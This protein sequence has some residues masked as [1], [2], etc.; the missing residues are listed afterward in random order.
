MRLQVAKGA[1]AS[2]SGASMIPMMLAL[3]VGAILSG[4]GLST[5]PR[6]DYKVYPILGMLLSAIA[7]GLYTLMTPDTPSYVLVG[8]LILGGLGGGISVMVPMIVAQASVDVRDVA[9]ATSSMQFFQSIAGLLCIAIMQV[10]SAVRLAGG[11]R[12]QLAAG[13]GAAAVQR[14]C[15]TSKRHEGPLSRTPTVHAPHGV[16]SHETISLR[17]S[18]V[19][20]LSHHLRP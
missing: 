13:Q 18:R 8:N 19:P 14:P 11:V 20:P 1:T 10:R 7:S 5:F 17:P 15:S 2:E 12:A 9:T 4:I 6:L 16:A 3:P